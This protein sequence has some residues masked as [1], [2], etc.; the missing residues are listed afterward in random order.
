MI[1]E[2]TGYITMQMFE[3]IRN[4]LLIL[5]VVIPVLVV[6]VLI[7]KL[8]KYLFTGDDDPRKLIYLCLEKI[9]ISIT[10]LFICFFGIRTFLSDESV[11]KL[12][13][14]GFIRSEECLNLDKIHIKG[15]SNAGNKVT[16]IIS[17]KLDYSYYTYEN[18]KYTDKKLTVDANDDNKYKIIFYDKNNRKLATYELEYTYHYEEKVP[19][20]AGLTE[21]IESVYEPDQ[22]VIE[23]DTSVSSVNNFSVGLVRQSIANLG[24]EV[25]KYH[26]LDF[27]YSGYVGSDSDHAK[28]MGHNS[29]SYEG[30]RFEGVRVYGTTGWQIYDKNG[31]AGRTDWSGKR[32]ILECAGYMNFIVRYATKMGSSSYS[33]FWNN[34]GFKSVN[35]NDGLIP[36][37]LLHFSGHYA[38][39]VGKVDGVDTISEIYNSSY[40]DKWTVRLSKLDFNKIIGVSRFMTLPSNANYNKVVSEP[41]LW[42]KAD[43]EKPVIT[44]VSY[45]NSSKKI[46]VTAYDKTTDIFSDTNGNGINGYAIT[47]SS[48]EPVEWNNLNYNTGYETVKN[49]SFTIDNIDA[50]TYYVWVRDRGGNATSYLIT[51]Y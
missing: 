49:A 1:L 39:Y 22:Y 44:S 6:I 48:S 33:N 38:I 13:Q 16:L 51:A 31:N 2:C 23:N 41:T 45:D 21:N 19:D 20:D 11:K 36:G 27:I 5:S 26:K 7:V 28:Y 50:G 3:I 30:K 43:W 37:D 24:I 14:K 17:G 4:I 8:F 12:D 18:K 42:A 10:A 47:T 25:A 15:N 9:F 40:P 46:M 35:K 32:F 34:N 29:E